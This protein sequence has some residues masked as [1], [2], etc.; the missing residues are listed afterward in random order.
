[1]PNEITTRGIPHKK[2]IPIIDKIKKR[3]FDSAVF[4]GICNE[5]GI[6][7][8]EIPLIPICF[9]KIPVSARTDHGVIYINIDLIDNDIK[10]SVD[11]NAHYLVHEVTHYFQQTTGSKPTPAS[12]EDD[13]LDN[14][15]EQE[16]FQNQIEYISDTQGE[17][18]AEEYAD[19]V[20]DHHTNTDADDK[21]REKRRKKLLELASDFFIASCKIC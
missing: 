16:G 13:Y 14:K 4:K 12:T 2:L 10:K 20:L 21:K 11:D 3:V 17:D 7:E 19:Q 15:T 6:R 18:V 5:Y 1:M 8:E 9:A